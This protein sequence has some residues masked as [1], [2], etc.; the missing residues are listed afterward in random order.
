MK[1]AQIWTLKL[2]R[3]FMINYLSNLFF[4]NSRFTKDKTLI[5]ITHRLENIAIYDKI[6]V[7]N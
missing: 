6:V 1:Q 7:L 5:V 2:T 4:I 3:N